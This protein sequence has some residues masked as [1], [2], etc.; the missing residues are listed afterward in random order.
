MNSAFFKEVQ[1]RL[2]ATLF[3]SIGQGVAILIYCK[4][5]IV[6]TLV[7]SHLKQQTSDSSWEFLKI[8]NEQIKTA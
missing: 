6:T 7:T 3:F 8:E 2:E 5:F 4:R 1:V